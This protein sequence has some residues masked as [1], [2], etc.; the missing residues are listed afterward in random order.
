MSEL[1]DEFEPTAEPVEEPVTEPTTEEAASAEEPEQKEPEPEPKVEEKPQMVPLATYLDE[2]EKRKALE[3]RVQQ[4]APQ[5]QPL[6]DVIDDPQGFAGQIQAQVVSAAQTARLDVS[7]VMAR[8]KYGDE[9][10]DAAFK[11][12]VEQGVAQNF[13]N[14]KHAYGALVDW[15]KKQVLAAEIGDPAKYREKLKAEIRA[16][17]EAEQVATQIKGTPAPSLAGE[18][19]IG[20]RPPVAPTL[21]PLDDILG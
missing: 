21:T 13:V 10:V 9:A 12:A 11:A 8:E 7:E 14:E 17:F 6:P 16:E 18:T 5:P 20:G 19:S 2:R 15:H 1:E 4:P 3:Q